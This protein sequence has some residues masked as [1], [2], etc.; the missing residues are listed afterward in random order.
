[1]PKYKPIGEKPYETPVKNIVSPQPQIK[2]LKR[3]L[4]TYFFGNLKQLI[5]IIINIIK[6][7]NK[8]IETSI[9]FSIKSEKNF[10]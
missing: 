1:M 7:G 4:I 5:C 8:E 3:I 10:G 6:I 2:K 9:I